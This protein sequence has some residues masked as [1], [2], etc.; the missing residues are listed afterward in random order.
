MTECLPDCAI[1]DRQLEEAR[2]DSIRRFVLHGEVPKVTTKRSPSSP[3]SHT[4][5]PAGSLNFLEGRPRRVS[6]MLCRQLEAVVDD[7]QPS[8]N[9]ATASPPERLRKTIDIVILALAFQASLQQGAYQPD[10]ECLELCGRLLKVIQPYLASTV[11]PIPGQNL[12]WRG[13]APL[14]QTY[15]TASETWPIMLKPDAPSGIRPDLLPPSGYS[16]GGRDDEELAGSE[17]F[18]ALQGQIWAL[19][20]VSRAS[21]IIQL[22]IADLRVARECH[23][24][25]QADG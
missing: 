1:V 17:Q 15:R 10:Q 23:S 5:E 20:S 3:Q 25:L 11:Y 14:V 7:W 8:E 16:V 19:P 24:A 4:S 13:F 2:T 9:A 21:S 22:T 6:S 12:I 18:T